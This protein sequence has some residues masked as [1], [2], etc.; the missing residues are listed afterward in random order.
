MRENGL[1]EGKKNKTGK[2]GAHLSY[3]IS[4]KEA[5]IFR[6]NPNKPELRKGRYYLQEGEKRNQIFLAVFTCARTE[7]KKGWTG[8]RMKKAEKQL[9]GSGL[10]SRESLEGCST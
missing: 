5:G 6:W 4:Q 3:R 2:G 8:T 1:R 10:D 7:G 9:P